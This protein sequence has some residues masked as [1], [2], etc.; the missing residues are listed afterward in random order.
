MKQLVTLTVLFMS[1]FC[2]SQTKEIDS[3]TVALAFQERDSVKIETSL[4]LIEALYNAKSY[5]KALKYIDN[6]EQLSKALN[7]KKGIADA[8][9]YKALVYVENNDYYNT[10]DRF[11]RAQKYYA[12]IN[13]SLGIAKVNN[14]IGLLEI[15]R[16]NYDLG[17]KRSLSAIHIFEKRNYNSELSAAYHNL[18]EAYYKTNQFDKSLSFNEKALE[19]REKLK[20]SSGIKISTSNIANL[21]SK[22]KEHRKAIEYYEKVLQLLDPKH[23]KI[24]KGE[25]LPRIGLE[26]LR[27]K[28][29]KKATNYLFNSLEFNKKTN[30]KDG[31][32]ITLNALGEMNMQLNNLKSAAIQIDEAERIAIEIDNQPELLKNYKLHTKLDSIKGQFQNAFSWQSKYY[33]LKEEISKENKLSTTVI[34]EDTDTQSIVY[35]NQPDNNSQEVL[36]EE[37]KAGKE[38]NSII[39]YILGAACLL[40]SSLFLLFYLK[41][42]KSFEVTKALKQNNAE[43]MSKNTALL[44]QTNHLEEVNNIKDRLFSIV[45]HDLKDSISSIKGFI[46]LL[47]EDSI[48]REEF[49]NLVPELSENANSASQ[50][51]YNLLNWSKS[52]MQNLEPNSEMF[53]IQDIFRDKI[54]LVEQKVEQKRIILLDE[55]RRDF[56][57]ADKS[58]IEIVIQNLITNAIKFTRI[59]DSIT[60]SNSDHNGKSLICVEDS[61]VGISRENIEKLFSNGTFSTRGTNNEKGTG[62]GLSIC[63]ELIELNNGRIWVESTPGI[64]SK[65]YVELPKSAPK[66]L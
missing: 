52:Q 38:S 11:N 20:D 5:S 48:S 22:R 61:G 16:G 8:N 33:D 49:Y 58:M 44:E 2:F 14:G 31:V 37:A 24:L 19:L 66:D 60:I 35:S 50:L 26:H 25:I 18:A 65:F 27:F 47:K 45:S 10:L 62:L 57:Y 15:K 54:S 51:L 28:D 1:L 41:H 42:K 63:K 43:L 23:D 9:Y 17:L 34:L 30:N 12:Q 4:K 29:Y 7:H 3:L 64:G 6:T 53:N 21:Y 40:I 59:G 56:I 46:D 32:L 36:K 39:T 13:D 55:S